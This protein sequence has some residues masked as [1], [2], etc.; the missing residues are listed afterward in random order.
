MESFGWIWLVAALLVILAELDS[1]AA[2]QTMLGQP[3][4]IGTLTGSLFGNWQAGLAAGIMLQLF[5]IDHLPLGGRIPPHLGIGGFTAALVASAV[6]SNL[7]PYTGWPL[8]Y[9][10]LW[11]AATAFLGGYLTRILRNINDRLMP[12][13]DLAVEECDTKKLSRFIWLGI[14]NHSVLAIV[15]GWI[16]AR[17]AVSLWPLITR[18]PVVFQKA[19]SHLPIEL[20]VAVGAL[21]LA[22]LHVTR[23]RTLIFA[24]PLFFVLLFLILQSINLEG[25]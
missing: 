4:V 19:E 15:A 21:S 23:S 6:S 22:R 17:I 5:W 2:F 3:V 9:G 12:I 8:L 11:G 7:F 20:F 16:P 25:S 14:L 24:A 13:V 1:T 18:I 10:I